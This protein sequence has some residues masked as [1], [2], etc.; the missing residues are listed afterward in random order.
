MGGGVP[1]QLC[2]VLYSGGEDRAI[3]QTGDVGSI[4][5]HR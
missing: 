5:N 4:N 2:G 3:V 1:Y